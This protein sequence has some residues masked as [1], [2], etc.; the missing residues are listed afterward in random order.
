MLL[1]GLAGDIGAVVRSHLNDSVNVKHSP[2]RPKISHQ[3]PF[4]T[5]APRVQR[6]QV[7]V[8]ATGILGETQVPT[9]DDSDNPIM[10]GMGAIRGLQEDCEW[11]FSRP[12][13]A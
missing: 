12:E 2:A 13:H 10:Q 3:S 4:C 7:S 1:F 6:H 5:T 11:L 8:D 9:L